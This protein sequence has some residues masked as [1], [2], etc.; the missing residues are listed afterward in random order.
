[1]RIDI[2]TIFPA[3]LD[4]LRQSL[5]GKA[6]ESGLVDLNVHD[7]RRWTHDVHHSVDDA[8]YGGGPGMVVKGRCGVKRLTKFVPA[9]RC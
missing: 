8:P 4:P 1:M 6:I 7:L 3:C 9:K 5:P 2:V